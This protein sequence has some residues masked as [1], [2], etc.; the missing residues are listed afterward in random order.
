[1][2]QTAP[3]FTIVGEG[4]ESGET[5]TLR[6]FERPH[7]AE[8][9]ISDMDTH[10]A[11]IS[12]TLQA[13]QDGLNEARNDLVAFDEDYQ[14]QR[15]LKVQ[16]IDHRGAVIDALN[17]TFDTVSTSKLQL[18]TLAN[19]PETNTEPVAGRKVTRRKTAKKG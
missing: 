13:E 11:A 6:P 7:P 8:A 2:T 12:D 18:Q 14:R 9:V 17:A 1:M 19:K 10:L 3:K 15:A 16:D 5:T 4:D